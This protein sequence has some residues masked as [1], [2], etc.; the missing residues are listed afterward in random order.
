MGI[1]NVRFIASRSPKRSSCGCHVCSS[2]AVTLGT[3][4]FD[5]EE[6]NSF[7]VYYLPRQS[8]DQVQPQ[9]S[10]HADD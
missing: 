1:H 3:Q 6:Y 2:R 10:N 8:N 7:V 5:F 9:R 4:N